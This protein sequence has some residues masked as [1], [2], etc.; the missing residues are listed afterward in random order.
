V[1]AWKINRGWDALRCFPPLHRA[2]VKALACSLPR[3]SGLPLSRWASRDIAAEVIH[4]GIVPGIS[5]ATVR[6]WLKA[7]ALRPW[8]YQTWIFPRDPAFPEKAGRVLDLYAGCWEGEPL[9]AGDY[10]I[11]ADEKTSL[12]ARSR[13]HATL[14]AEP[15]KLMRVEHEYARRGALAYL[16]AWDVRRAKL[17]GRCE[18]KT[19]IKPF[20][21]LVE[22]VMSQEPYRSADRVFWILDNGS[23]HRGRRCVERLQKTWPTLIPVHL[24]V[25]ASWLNQIEI[26]FSILQRKVL[27]PNDFRSLTVLTK[28]I[29]EFQERYEQMAEPFQWKFTRDDLADMMTKLSSPSVSLMQAA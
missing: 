15:E 14:P 23:S 24:P 2:E 22:E 29:L 6:R 12:Q 17:F 5:G 11:S 28:S 10:V 7:D 3:E 27:T 9:G 21:R 1:P 25:H 8:R 16:G 18:T 26:Y 19:G 13:K 20:E 4:R